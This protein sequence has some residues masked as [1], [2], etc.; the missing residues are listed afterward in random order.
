MTRWVHCKSQGYFGEWSEKRRI[1][2]GRRGHDEL[3]T[4]RTNRYWCLMIPLLPQL[5][6]KKAGASSVFGEA[7]ILKVAFHGWD[8]RGNKTLIH[9]A[10]LH[11]IMQILSQHHPKVKDK[12]LSFT[13]I[14]VNVSEVVAVIWKHRGEG[15][16]RLYGW[17]LLTSH[18][19]KNIP[20][21]QLLW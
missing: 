2:G 4:A 15:D 10:H 18:R 1:R 8:E 19:R 16:Q 12:E 21:H 5:H 20:P 17:W 7:A 13:P 11:S 6:E 9:S 3:V 14:T